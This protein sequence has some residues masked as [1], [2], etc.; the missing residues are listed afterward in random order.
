[1]FFLFYFV[2]MQYVAPCIYFPPLYLYTSEIL[3]LFIH[4]S[5]ASFL[6]ALKTFEY[7]GL[8]PF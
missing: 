5:N 8:A 7:F 2:S 6:F 4:F 3:S 1:M